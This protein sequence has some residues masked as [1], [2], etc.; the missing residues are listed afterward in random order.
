MIDDP[1]ALYQ[2]AVH[3][4]HSASGYYNHNVRVDR[5][6]QPLLVRIP[7]P[8]AATM[9][10]TIW[11][12]DAILAAVGPYVRNVPRLVHTSA[13]PRYQI[14]E[15]IDGQLL[16]AV[17]PRGTPVPRHVLSDA[18]RF[19]AETAEVPL[20]ALP[21]LPAGW[22]DDSDTVGFARRLSDVT[23]GVYARHVAAYAD[24]FA[25]LGF[26]A[27]PL[28]PALDGWSALHRRPFC[29]LH[30]DV[31]RKN[32]MLR[33]EQTVF[34][35]W[36]LALW[37]DPLYELAV[38]LHKMDYLSEEEEQVVTGWASVLGRQ[39][40]GWQDDLGRYLTHE[41]I[42]SAVVDTVRYTQEMLACWHDEPRRRAFGERLT[43]KVNRARP[44]WGHTDQLTTQAV[45][46]AVTAWCAVHTAQG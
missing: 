2:R 28:A 1:I 19:F 38:H 36:E 33:A 30:S 20:T 9:D 17:A 12:E 14:H 41:R 7:I 18:V 5:A 22:P 32:L 26:P 44:Y 21:T 27:D 29:L 37:G 13:E 16:E 11:P 8:S 40:V 6:G 35:D 39:S 45:D 25:E 31:H 24:L 10:L 4:N 15:F 43:R 34:I 3:T 42:K 46:K 23:E